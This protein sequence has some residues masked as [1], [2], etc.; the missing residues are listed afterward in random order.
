MS[1]FANYFEE[2]R[3][4]YEDFNVLELGSLFPF[5]D[6]FPNATYDIFYQHVCTRTLMRTT[7]TIFCLSIL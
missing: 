5:G 6:V 3:I 7:V 1:S 4:D 2:K